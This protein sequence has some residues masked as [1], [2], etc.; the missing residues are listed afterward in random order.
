MVT[1]PD[2][3]SLYRSPD[4]YQRVMAHYDAAFETMGIPF[5][6]RY[7][8]T[9]LGPAHAVISGNE[10]GK[11]VVLWH[12]QNANAASWASWIPSLAPAYHVYAI[13]VIGAMGKS[14][15]SRPA[16][17][18]AAYGEWAAEA[19]EAFGVGQ[20]NMIGASQGG[21]LIGKLGS[22]APDRVG[23]AVLMSSAGFLPLSM[24]EILRLLPRV[25]FK[26]TE[27][28]A[29]E[30]LA[31]VSA[32]DV[33]S[34]PFF[35]ELFELMMRYFRS[36]AIVPVLS[37]AE[38]QGLNAPTYLLM[39]QYESSF[40]P[41][42]ALERGLKLLPSVIAAEV[43]PGVGHSMIHRQPDWVIGRVA[44]FLERYAVRG[45]WHNDGSEAEIA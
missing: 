31:T 15:P 38:L 29:K 12:G 16:K 43:V 8:E 21:W 45:H 4:G 42:K 34:D 6:A 24:M 3:V 18:G 28:A 41:Y 22:V 37:D 2:N 19:L 40:D 27:E 25:L 44:G 14:A 39:G 10:E 1:P 36:E 9:S 5:E 11:P 26:P 20:A 35:L 13:D 23:T 33:P 32:P 7:V 17:K 30:M